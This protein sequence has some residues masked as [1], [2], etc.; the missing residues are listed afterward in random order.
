MKFNHI[1][2][3]KYFSSGRNSINVL[4]AA[5]CYKGNYIKKTLPNTRTL[6]NIKT[7]TCMLENKK[8][9]NLSSGQKEK[10]E[11]GSRN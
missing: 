4:Q 7:G 5:R 10:S 3:Y 11:L 8:L 6:P 9:L 2:Y 1:L